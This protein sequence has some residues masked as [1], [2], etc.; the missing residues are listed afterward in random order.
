MEMNE[1]DEPTP[2]QIAEALP[3]KW[4]YTCVK[5]KMTWQMNYYDLMRLTSRH[6]MP[7]GCNWKHLSMPKEQPRDREVSHE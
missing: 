7:C 1:A 5:C 2:E 6:E 3:L 4:S